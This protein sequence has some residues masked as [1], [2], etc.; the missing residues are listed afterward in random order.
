MKAMYNNNNHINIIQPFS[1]ESSNIR[2][3][4][5]KMDTVLE[6]IIRQHNYPLPVSYLLSE[7]LILSLVLSSMLKYDGIFT[8]QIQ[9][10][11]AIK[12]I[13]ADVNGQ[14]HIRAYVAFDEDAFKDNSIFSDSQNYFHL[15]EKGYMAFTVDQGENMDRYQGIVA[16]EGENLIDA[17]QHY[18]EQS[19]QIKTSVRMAIHPQDDQWCAGAIMIQSMPDS[20][21]E[22][23]TRAT[24]L[25]QTCDDDELLSPNLSPHDVLFRLFHEEGVRIYE[26]T[27][28]EH[29]CRCSKEKVSE[30]LKS[31][32][33][34]DL[35]HTKNK[36]GEIK[37]QC[38]FCG[39]EYIFKNHDLDKT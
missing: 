14:G 37:I 5:I 9:A 23:W 19:E 17:M 30:V 27:I 1:L 28:I 36:D 6:Q 29:I 38:E 13:V 3:R 8:L 10:E 34:D 35:E 31:L 32:P 4:L 24:M 16:L 39:K 11:G 25:L 33:K 12:T 7:A 21:E 15:L 2:G 18:F 26:P 22:D 20:S